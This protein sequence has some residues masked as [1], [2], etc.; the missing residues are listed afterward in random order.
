MNL[1]AM[2]GFVALAPAMVRPLAAQDAV[3]VVNLDSPVAVVEERFSSIRGVRELSSGTVLVADWLE[4]H[5]SLVDLSTG[6]V[7]LRVDTGPGPD[8][9]RLPSGLIPMA[10]DS[11]L[12]IDG[13]NGRLAVLDSNG[14]AV[15]MIRADRVASSAQSTV[16]QGKRPR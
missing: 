12:L 1:L 14:F 11:T 15:R 8:E 13:G 3:P 16:M 10:G 5:V 7:S 6:D 2:L 9:V 4:E